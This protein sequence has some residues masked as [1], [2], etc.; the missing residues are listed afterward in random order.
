VRLYPT[1]ATQTAK[2]TGD[3]LSNCRQP[4]TTYYPNQSN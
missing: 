4:S 3:N 2:K 1:S